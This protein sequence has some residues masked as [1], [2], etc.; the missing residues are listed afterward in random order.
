VNLLR[1]T[2]RGRRGRDGVE[3]VPHSE[4]DAL[5][6]VDREGMVTAWD[7]RARQLLGWPPRQAL[8]RPLGDLIV[9]PAD[10][11][12]YRVALNNLA[13]GKAPGS[14][15]RAEIT[16]RHRDGRHVPVELQLWR[17]GTGPTL[18]IQAVLR[19]ITERKQL[20]ADLVAARDEALEASR[21]TSRFL[22]TMSHEIRTPMNSV[23]GL[24]ELLLDTL[25]DDAQRRYAEGIH[26]AGKVL[27]SVINDIL[28]F[29][30]LEAGK[31][32]LEQIVFDPARLLCVVADVFAQPAAD[33]G[34]ELTVRSGPGLPAAVVGDAARLKQ[35]LLNLTSNAVKFTPHGTVRLTAAPAPDDP[36][37]DVALPRLRFEVADTGIGIAKEDRDRLFEPF[38]QADASTTRRFGGT[39]LG[40]AICKRLV[41]AM[42][43][44]IG[45]ESEPG[46]GTVVHCVIPL[47]P[48][49][50][51]VAPDAPASD[52]DGLRVLIVDDDKTN[53]TVLSGQL[54]S[55]GTRPDAFAKSLDALEALRAAVDQGSPYDLAILDMHMP[56][57]DGLELARRITADAHLRRV[58]LVLLTSGSVPEPDSM[59]EAGIAAVL[60]KPVHR[61]QLYDCLA[62][63]L[64]RSAQPGRRAPTHGVADAAT[65]EQQRGH[66]LLVEDNEINQTVALGFLTRLGYTADIASTGEQA[67]SMIAGIQ[68]DAVLMDCQMPVMD[69]YVATAELRRREGARKHTPVIAMTASAQINDRSRCIAAGM[70]DY[71]PKPLDADT[72]SAA[73]VRWIP[74]AEHRPRAAAPGAAHVQPVFQIADR[75]RELEGPD[76]RQNH[77]TFARICAMFTSQT[78][79]ALADLD[80]A[81]A[82][83]DSGAIER[84]S[85]RLKGSA[86]NIGAAAM[87]NLCQELEA[88]AHDGRLEQAQQLLERL[89]IEYALVSEALEDLMRSRP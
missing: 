24:T 13:R 72:L 40:M 61:S 33:K 54:R 46:V 58:H 29:S 82:D 20:E 18:S 7:E 15:I 80:A 14:V 49:D 17:T 53:R 1:W 27:L 88:V 76:P 26:D 35:I 28:D 62:G 2:G 51:R 86:G 34:L 36:G 16:V 68:Y 19:D 11:P 4:L 5:V 71:V 47:L 81:I 66:V 8:G 63:I 64:G 70:D 85:H 45:L 87:A 38:V 9:S 32:V 42:G 21:A 89:Q 57:V 78:Q 37:A 41:L 55:W 59:R 39:G 75:L 43:G 56:V 31:V 77:E 50:E 60:T 84:E 10:R 52:F 44:E 12:A 6:S 22:A 73:L 74:G 67:L 23:L 25:L 30:K 3:K 48:T 65:P 79:T 69:G 83:G